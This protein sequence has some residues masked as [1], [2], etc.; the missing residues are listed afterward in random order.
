M[1]KKL[2][3]PALF[4]LL[5]AFF[6]ACKKQ[7]LKLTTTEE[8]NIVGYL[9]RQPDSFSLIRNILDRTGNTDFL[10]AYGAYTF[11]APTNS[12]ISAWLAA[13]GA[14]RV[15]DVPAEV[16]KELVNFH[17]VMDTMTTG[18][19]KDGRLPVATMQG[20]FLITGVSSAGGASSY[21]I[22][23][24]ARVTRSN[25]K[26]GNGYIHQIDHVLVPAR[27]TIA[28]QLAENPG[29]SIFVEALKETG[30]YDLLHTVEADT[31]KRWKT[32]IAE[33]NKALADS[34]IASYD[35]LK[36]RYSQLK[37][38]RNPKDS[39]HRYV[40][41]HILDG[42]KF[43]GDIL[44]FP[45]HATLEPQEVI[46]TQV[47]GQEVVVN[48]DLFDGVLEKGVPLPR[49]SSDNAATNGVWHDAAGHFMVKY[50]KP[51]AVYWDV[52]TF[53]EIM[54]MPAYYKKQN[55]TFIRQN[56]ADRPVKSIIWDF[57]G[58]A[59]H[60]VYGW[61]TGGSITNFACNND[62]LTLPLGGPNRATWWEFTTPVIIKGRYKVW[63]CY[64]NRFA[65]K[66][67]VRID[68]ELMQRPVNFG[69]GYPAGTDE[70]L[71]SLNWKR[72]T[73]GGIFAGRMV[74]VVDIQTTGR[75]VFRLE[76]FEGTNA[77]NHLD[78]VHFIPADEH[79]FLPRFNPDG[80][81]LYK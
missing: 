38:P 57:K 70:E 12:G 4:L 79:Q 22:N 67:N 81:K 75:H 6:P 7:E 41:Y 20:Q 32:V 62:L 39:L 48:E 56:A 17:L 16:L 15:E 64:R 54:N 13:Q 42:I 8:V 14:A 47:I 28:E 27:K 66:C 73:A 26:V 77:E 44:P 46:S 9:D 35:A 80:S 11:F 18:S 60:F 36:D 34:G 3:L 19:F 37:D 52:A 31:A 55:F 59:A 29:Y 25:I 21:L 49:A 51:A 69:E 76:P 2:M 71:E 40:A 72:Y 43:L 65:V 61:G 53:P 50:R 45:S 78:M 68:G 5:G 10:N 63:V 23:R 1:T 24:Q 33:S 58:A 30:F 74:G